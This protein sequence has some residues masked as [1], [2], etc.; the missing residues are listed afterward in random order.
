MLEVSFAPNGIAREEFRAPSHAICI[1]PTLGLHPAH[2]A[3]ALQKNKMITD[4]LLGKTA[5]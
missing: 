3:K 5:L 1:T 2:A 4:G